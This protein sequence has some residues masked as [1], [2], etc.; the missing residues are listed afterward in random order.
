VPDAD[1][2]MSMN[3]TQIIKSL[4]TSSL[5][6]GWYAPLEAAREDPTVE[7]L[8]YN[9]ASPLNPSY[10]TYYAEFKDAA[11]ARA[12]I[13][14]QD[15]QPDYS[16]YDPTGTIDPAQ[17]CLDAGKLFGIGP[18]GSNSLG[19]ESAQRGFTKI[20]SLVGLGIA[21]IASLIMMG[22]VGKMIADS[23]RETAV[24]RAIGAKK[25][26]IAQVYVLYTIFLSVLITLFAVV[27]GSIAVLVANAHF[28][29]QITQEALV[30]YNA[31]DLDK[32]FTLYGFYI[33]DML[34]LLG[35]AVAAGL[36]SALFPLIRNLR[37]NP[38][39][40]MRDDT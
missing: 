3:V 27:V 30:A 22:T 40:D 7:T 24:F 11:A 17:K 29:P 21:V 33:P 1:Y 38:I 31:Q 28:A 10:A 34:Y 6:S 9:T 19:L 13:D 4:V 16:K 20:F 25:L 2:G 32:S 14:K 39:K 8:F 26:D 12:F 5:G 15:C 36:L 35:I 23:R 37:R 18:Y